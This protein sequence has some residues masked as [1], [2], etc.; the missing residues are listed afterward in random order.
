MK[1]IR[2]NIIT[3]LYLLYVIFHIKHFTTF[4]TYRYIQNDNDFHV[5]KY[6]SL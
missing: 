5:M 3:K 4:L 2:K 1:P 6:Y